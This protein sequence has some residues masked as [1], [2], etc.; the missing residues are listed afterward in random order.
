MLSMT[1]TPE[2]RDIIDIARQACGVI[3]VR[4]I[5]VNRFPFPCCICLEEIDDESEVRLSQELGF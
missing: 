5:P 3:R 4:A 1:P 2:G